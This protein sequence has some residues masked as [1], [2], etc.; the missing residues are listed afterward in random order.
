[1]L[2]FEEGE[3]GVWIWRRGEVVGSWEEWRETGWDALYERT[4]YYQYI[5]EKKVQKKAPILKQK[6]EKEG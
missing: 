4:I 6:E 3:E 1:M 5:K 2:F